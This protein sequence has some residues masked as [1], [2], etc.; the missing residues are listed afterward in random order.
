MLTI[1]GYSV[2]D[3]I[4]IFDRVRENMRS[5]RRENLTQIVNVAVNQTLSRT[6]ITAGTTLL[7][8]IAL[9]LFGGEVLR[10]FRLHDA[11]R[12]HQRHLFDRLHRR[13]DR[14]HAA[15]AEADEGTGG[16]AADA[17]TAPQPSSRLVVPRR[18]TIPATCTSESPSRNHSRD[19]AGTH[20]VP[21][22]LEL[23]ASDP[24]AGVFRLGGPERL[25]AR[26]RRRAARRHA[27]GDCA[28]TSVPTSWRWCARFRRR[29]R[30]R[31]PIGRRGCC[32]ASPSAR[33]GRRRR[34]L[35]QRFHRA[36]ACGRRP[37]RR[38]RWRWARR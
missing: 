34:P 15:G 1:T 10:R 30:R 37:S 16:G 12:H 27:G 9:Y 25:R 11:R 14:D 8:V 32:T 4:V 13:G 29:S 26:L 28:P 23:G 24:R 3:T 6:V 38:W 20:R 21:A 31:R 5:M 2:N 7:S 18:L 35:L 22:R 33:P 19:R 17:G 36:L